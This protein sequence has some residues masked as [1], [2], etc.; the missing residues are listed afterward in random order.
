MPLGKMKL[1][2]R[3]G[4]KRLQVLLSFLV[5]LGLIGWWMMFRMPGHS[6]SGAFPSLTATEITIQN[7]LK[8]DVEM[9]AG[10]I[11]ERNFIFYDNLLKSQDFLTDSLQNMGYQVHEQIYEIN[12]KAYANL[13][14]EIPGT[15]KPDEI[16]VIGAHYDSVA[17]SPGANDNGTGAAAVLSLARQ[18]VNQPLAKTLRF[19]EFVNEEPP[20]FWT[21]NMGSLVYAKGC[22]ERGEK[23][24]GMLSLETIGYY[25][26]EPKSQQY[27]S[28]L[29]LV[30]PTAG[31]FIGFVGNL[32]SRKLVERVISAFRRHVK[33]PSE[34]VT[35]PNVLP[36]IGWSDHWSFWQQG[37]PAAMVTDT[38]PFRYPYYHTTEDTPDKVDYERTARVVAGL[39]TV[40]E[41]I[42]GN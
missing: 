25:S 23:I 14:V 35:M 38:A 13:E 41:E 28:P 6:Y 30:Y 12:G 16:I 8:R 33:Y 42:G 17:G 37:Y 40:I 20:F 2:S 9:L 3:R 1:I 39:V 7:E 19:V 36:G 22:R 26:E 15:E 29:N 18:F 4:V 10:E 21:E 5:V 27:P 32:D 31:N 24:V 11:G 34:G